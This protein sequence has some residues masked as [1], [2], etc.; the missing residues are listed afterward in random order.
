MNISET[1]T[2]NVETIDPSKTIRQAGRKMCQRGVGSLPVIADD[3]LI[4]M[5]TDRDI[6][7]FAVAMGRDPNTTE[8]RKAMSKDVVT[9]FD[10]QDISYA[11]FLMQDRN[12]R[13]LVV[14][15]KNEKVVGII[16]I[17]DLARSSN[18]LAG[19][20]LQAYRRAH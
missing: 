8:V 17:E 4:G 19:S 9:C 2:S 3:K 5:I 11:A 12:I 20:V 14:I 7:C 10:D 1:M 16:S 13:R 6:S 15:N 18:E